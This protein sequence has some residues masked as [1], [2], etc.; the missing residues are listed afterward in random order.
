MTTAGTQKT[1]ATHQRNLQK[2]NNPK[3]PNTHEYTTKIFKKKKK[4]KKTK[5][6][7]N[8]T[9]NQSPQP[10]HV[11]GMLRDPKELLILAAVVVGP[12]QQG[13]D[14]AGLFGQRTQVPFFL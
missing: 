5:H 9:I 6:E 14:T 4:K 1:L 12:R 3:P 13:S 10:G 7:Q 11:H 2:N 8:E